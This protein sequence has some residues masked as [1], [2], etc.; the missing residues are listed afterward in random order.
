MRA[1]MTE[2][3]AK[4]GGHATATHLIAHQFESIY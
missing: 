2:N 3:A 1:G 4:I